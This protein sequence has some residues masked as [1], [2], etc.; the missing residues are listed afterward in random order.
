MAPRRSQSQTSTR[1][2]SGQSGGGGG[3]AAAGGGGGTGGG[4]GGPPGGG[5]GGGQPGG[6]N[7]PANPPVFGLTPGLAT[8]GIIDYT[9]KAGASLYRSATQKVS[10]ELYDCSPDDFYQFI[11]K[12][13]T[14]AEEFGWTETGRILYCPIDETPGAEHVNLLDEFGQV[15]LSTITTHEATVINTQ[16]RKAQ[17]DRLLY[18]CLGN[19]LSADGEKKILLHR[20]EY[21]IE[22]DP[23]LPDGKKLPSGLCLLKV[24][25]RESHL[26][27]NATTGMIRTKLSN[28]DSYVQVVG[29]DITKFNGYVKML[30]DTLA[31]RGETTQDLLTN[32]FKGYGSCSDKTFVEYIAKKQDEYDE[33]KDFTPARLMQLADTKYRTMKDKEIWEAPSETDEKILALEARLE[34]FK[35]KYANAKRGPGKGGDD[36]PNPNPNKNKSSEKGKRKQ[37]EKPSWMLKRPSDAE[38]NKPRE[39]NGKTWHWCSK[40]TGGKCDPGAYRIHKPSQCEG[41]AHKRAK[42]GKGDSN[43]KKVT[44]NEAIDEAIEEVVGGYESE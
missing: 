28:L 37:T 41:K 29:N 36:K 12:V 43:A 25:I 2:A 42:T 7:P 31:S 11:Q 26:D 4:G 20:D 22:P 24:I 38:L 34:N 5:G 21:V 9:T 6:N 39:W 23:R 1:T 10:E 30:L 40:E 32:L 27:T 44:I 19:S 17:D 18:E 8:Q 35:K 14:R 15:A 16:T 3:A 33:G 13:K